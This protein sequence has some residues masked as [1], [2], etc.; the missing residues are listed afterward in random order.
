MVVRKKKKMK[1]WLKMLLSFIGI[2]LLVGGAAFSYTFYQLGKVQTVK[3]SKTNDD[4]GI[5]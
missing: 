5:N 2:L 4:L 3:I 1:L